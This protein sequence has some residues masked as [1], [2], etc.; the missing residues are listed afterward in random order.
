MPL[1]TINEN[2]YT[3]AKRMVDD[4]KVTD[5]HAIIPTDKNPNVGELPTEHKNIYLMVIRRFIAAFLPECEKSHTEIIASAANETFKATGPLIKVPGWRML[6]QSEDS[7]K[8]KDALL[9]NVEKGDLCDI[10]KVTKKKGQTKR[11]H[12]TQKPQ[13]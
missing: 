2:N 13:F 11:L 9:P 10:K 5:H 12:F 3:I 6:A 4:K 7:K 8:D 1:E